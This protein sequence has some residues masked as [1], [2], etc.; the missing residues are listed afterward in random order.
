MDKDSAFKS[1]PGWG[2]QM[3]SLYSLGVY[4]KK[5]YFIFI[6]W[7]YPGVMATLSKLFSQNALTDGP[8]S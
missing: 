6:L 3:F 8:Y 4:G 1:L 5:F 2:T 7:G